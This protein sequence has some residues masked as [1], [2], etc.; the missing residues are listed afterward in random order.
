[1][2]RLDDLVDEIK[3]LNSQLNYKTALRIHTILSNNRKLFIEKMDE[4]VVD[5]SIT[6][7]DSLAQVDFKEQSTDNYLR[8]FR[9]AFENL[10]FYINKII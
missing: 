9:N 5:R 2:A 8:T 3:Q 4:E 10:L 1:M 7:F 6:N